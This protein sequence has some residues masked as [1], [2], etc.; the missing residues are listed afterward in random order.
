MIDYHCFSLNGDLETHIPEKVASEMYKAIV[1]DMHGF[2]WI[3][4][5]GLKC[6][7]SIQNHSACQPV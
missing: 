1:Q 3:D 4:S 6:V 2:P 7:E 5:A